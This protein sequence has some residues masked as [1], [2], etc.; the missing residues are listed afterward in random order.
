MRIEAKSSLVPLPLRTAPAAPTRDAAPTAPR[1]ADRRNERTPGVLRHLAD[2]H[3]RGVADVRLRIV[4]HDELA[5]LGAERVG[6][7]SAPA[8][9]GAAH[10]KFLAIYEELRSASATPVADDPAVDA[11]A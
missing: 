1:D 10:A 4:F 2:G 7:L 8:G 3:Y 11:V 9:N 5:A 6:E